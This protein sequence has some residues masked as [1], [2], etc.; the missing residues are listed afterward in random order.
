MA[1]FFLS[2]YLWNYHV[3]AGFN[4]Q[5]F[6]MRLFRDLSRARTHRRKHGDHAVVARKVPL[7]VFKESQSPHIQSQTHS[8]RWED[9]MTAD[10]LASMD[11]ED[12]RPIYIAIMG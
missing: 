5:L 3:I 4:I 11:G 10:E 8:S 9:F 12:G 7:N 1:G 2:R 6:L